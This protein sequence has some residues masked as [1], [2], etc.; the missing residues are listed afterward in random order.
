MLNKPNFL[1]LFLNSFNEFNKRIIDGLGLIRLF[2]WFQERCFE[3][4]VWCMYSISLLGESYGKSQLAK[5]FQNSYALE[6]YG[7]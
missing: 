7:G 4:L 6:S 2:F 1:S 3:L 5:Y